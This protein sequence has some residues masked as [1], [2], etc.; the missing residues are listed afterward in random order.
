MTKVL[1][2]FKNDLNIHKTF[3]MSKITLKNLQN[4]RNTLKI[5]KM[6]EILKKKTFHLDHWINYI[7]KI[8]KL[9]F[10]WTFEIKSCI[11]NFQSY[12]SKKNLYDL[13]PLIP[14]PLLLIKKFD[15]LLL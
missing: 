5:S 1:S 11:Y 12:L 4:Y 14:I 7:K 6:I 2:N 15:V 8:K 3:K 9:L 10:D 13:N